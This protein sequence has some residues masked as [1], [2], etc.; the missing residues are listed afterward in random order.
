ML[1]DSGDDGQ[2]LE[3]GRSGS[4]KDERRQMEIGRPREATVDCKLQVC[5][6]IAVAWSS[7][8]G[9]TIASCEHGRAPVKLD[10]FCC[11]GES[12][13]GAVVCER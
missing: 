8:L 9:L 10:C 5:R 4:V 2:V 12:G 11:H 6:D 1:G 7:G 13:V 3:H